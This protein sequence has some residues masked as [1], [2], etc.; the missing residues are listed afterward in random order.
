MIGF[1]G[2]Q[3]V[4]W[5]WGILLGVVFLSCGKKGTEPET[6]PRI[7]SSPQVSDLA[8]ASVRISWWTDQSADSRIDYGMSSGVYDSARVEE[9]E[10]TYHSLLLT[11]L[12]MSTTYYFVVGSSNENGTVVSEEDTFRT[13]VSVA[14]LVEQGWSCYEDG[15]YHEAV[16]HFRAALARDDGLVASYNGLGWSY[17]SS[18]VD[19]LERARESFDQALILQAD[20]WDGYAGRGCVHLALKAYDE[21]VSDLLTVLDNDPDYAFLH[22]PLVTHE[23]L[24]L[25]LAE[26]YFYKNRYASAQEQVDALAPENGLNPADSGS[27]VVDATVYATYE[28][29]LLALIEALKQVV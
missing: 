21:A 18:V 28:E 1:G 24:R 12:R 2:R 7:V 11:G 22:N 27:W 14:Y 8:D 25:A 3:N 5:I 10:G 15:S 20:L 13:D 16:D 4:G 17:A 26:C 6:R 29:A 19:S 23:D 9:A